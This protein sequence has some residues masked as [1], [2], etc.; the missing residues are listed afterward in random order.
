MHVAIFF[1]LSHI[2]WHKKMVR[3]KFTYLD[4]H[5]YTLFLKRLDTYVKIGA[6]KKFK[7]CIITPKKKQSCGYKQQHYVM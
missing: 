2:V 3:D 1:T 7:R 4:I 6:W 5:F